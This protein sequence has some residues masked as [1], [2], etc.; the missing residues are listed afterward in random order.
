MFY[1]FQTYIL[2]NDQNIC[3]LIDGEFGV[4]EKVIGEYC[5]TNPPPVCFSL[6]NNSSRYIIIC[7]LSQNSLMC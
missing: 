1:N 3:R 4:N 6:A 2:L 5:D 7:S